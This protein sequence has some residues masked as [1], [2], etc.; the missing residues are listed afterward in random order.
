MLHFQ[1]VLL[2]KENISFLCAEI[3]KRESNAFFTRKRS[4][5]DF[6]SFYG[7]ETPK[8]VFEILSMAC[9]YNRADIAQ[10]CSYQGDQ[11]SVCKK[12]PKMFPSP[13]C[14]ENYFMNLT[15]E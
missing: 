7:I 9:T 6:G 8:S 2:K 13:F 12:S 5:Q 4:S 14:C 11:M 10:L 3:L 15:V 1:K